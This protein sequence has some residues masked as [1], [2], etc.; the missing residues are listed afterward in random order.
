M[1]NVQR[2]ICRIVAVVIIGMMVYLPSDQ[3]I[4]GSILGFEYKFIWQLGVQGENIFKVYTPNF[5]LLIAQIFGVAVT[6]IFL[7]KSFQSNDLADK[8]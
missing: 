1:N 5:G 8:V 7:I 3:T 6:A 2:L 4:H